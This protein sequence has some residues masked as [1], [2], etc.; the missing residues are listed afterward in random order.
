MD[1]NFIEL[2]VRS[3]GEN[4]YGVGAAVMKLIVS[5]IWISLVVLLENVR[6]TEERDWLN[7]FT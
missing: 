6:K 3:R 1:F 2:F 5:Q 4:T 7:K